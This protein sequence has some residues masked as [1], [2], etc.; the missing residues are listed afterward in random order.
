[1]FLMSPPH[2]V[3]YGRIT[4]FFLTASYLHRS[5]R[6]M[7]EWLSWTTYVMQT[8]YAGTYLTAQAFGGRSQYDELIQDPELNRT[9]SAAE[10]HAYQYANGNAYANHRYPDA[11]TDQQIDLIACFVFPVAA[12]VFNVLLYV[13]PLPSYVKAKFRE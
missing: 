10:T 9:V 13:A 11:V 5:Y 2:T 12:M 8:R 1:M 3:Q 6:G 7:S 4:D